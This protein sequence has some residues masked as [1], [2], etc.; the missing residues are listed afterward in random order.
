ML[1]HEHLR[2]FHR[3]WS[4]FKNF[5]MNL[6]DW[7]KYFLIFTGFWASGCQITSQTW[8]WCQSTFLP[9][10]LWKMAHENQVHW[11]ENLF[12]LKIYFCFWNFP[13]LWSTFIKPF[14][15]LSSIFTIQQI[16]F[17]LQQRKKVCGWIFYSLEIFFYIVWSC[18]QDFFV[19]V[20]RPFKSRTLNG[21]RINDWQS[22]KA[23]KGRLH[24]SLT[25][26][27]SSLSSP[28][29]CHPF[30]LNEEWK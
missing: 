7:I 20:Q 13:F 28:C 25:K 8:T 18:F 9:E 17:W 29:N 10:M 4:A 19:N 26:F 3:F 2:E 27:V 5:S 1:N 23:S 12:A 11:F 6:Q 14:L 24:E 30:H 21:S 15:K 22:S 16:F